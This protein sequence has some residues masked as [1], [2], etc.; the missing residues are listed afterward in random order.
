MIPTEAVVLGDIGQ[1]MASANPK[2]PGLRPK[3]VTLGACVALDGHGRCTVYDDRPFMCHLWGSVAFMKCAYGCVPEGGFMGDVDALK[4]I[5]EWS[6]IDEAD[7]AGIEFGQALRQMIA[8]DAELQQAFLHRVRVYANRDEIF[9]EADCAQADI[10]LVKALH[11]AQ[12]RWR[13]AATVK[14]GEPASRRT[15]PPNRRSRRRR[16]R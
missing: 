15:G 10:L 7:P 12:G 16:N 14:D 1:L 8:S 9:T 3:K 13:E 11:A 2:N 4:A 6:L 5:V